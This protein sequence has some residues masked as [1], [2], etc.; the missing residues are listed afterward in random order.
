VVS[1]S[2]Q[3][4]HQGVRGQLLLYIVPVTRQHGMGPVP[5]VTG[6]LCPGLHGL[7]DVR[8][9]GVAVSDPD[10]DPGLAEPRDEADGARPLGRD[11]REPNEAPRGI[12]KLPEEIPVRIADGVGGVR[13]ARTILRREKGPSR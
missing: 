9:L 1:V 10:H 7:V 4:G 6:N 2:N 11:R 8:L 5:E 3:R 13:A 12:L